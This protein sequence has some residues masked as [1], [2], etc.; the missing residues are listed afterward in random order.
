[1]EALSGGL[2]PNKLDV[3]REYLQNSYDAIRNYVEEGHEL[4]D[5]KIRVLVQ[6]RSVVIQDN[7]GGM[8]LETLKEY[9][10]MGFS[11][12][13]FGTYAGWRGI[14]KAA[15]L[16]VAEKLIVSTAQESNTVGYQLVFQASQMLDEVRQLRRSGEN[17]PFN[18]LIS[19][20]TTIESFEKDDPKDHFTSVELRNVRKEMPELLDPGLIHAHLSQI[21]PVP[22]HSDF[23]HGQKIQEQ[24]AEHLEEYL[25]LIV[26]VNENRV[27]K[28]YLD[29]WTYEEEEFSVKDPEFLPVYNQERE[30]VSFAWYCMNQGKGQIRGPI[31]VADQAV[32][33]SGLVYRLYDIRIGDAQLCRST[34]WR[35]TPERAF[36]AIGEVHVVDSRVEPTSDR[37]D[38]VDNL[39]R[40]D[41]YDSCTVI[42]K[43][44][45]RKAG[46]QSEEL[47]AEEK[48]RTASS[49]VGNISLQLSQGKVSREVVPLY[50]QRAMNARDEL[51]RRL[52]KTTKEETRRIGN[53]A[54]EQ[55]SL[56][57]EQLRLGLEL[58]HV[59]EQG[60][61]VPTQFVDIMEELSLSDEARQVY[62]AVMK[63]VGEFFVDVPGFYEEMVRRIHLELRRTFQP[64]GS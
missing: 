14:G 38:F 24:L 9:R 13:P 6:G 56:L 27:F 42:A 34:I 29:T 26:F 62:D 52:P 16:A 50:I 35:A 57:I 1:L 5:C 32:N 31:S 49:D 60:T 33:V 48:V 2:Y 19:K 28:P 53:S 25:P 36:Y 59:P 8:D 21:A 61:L 11:K 58:P 3:L 51:E 20:F 63:A 64:K 37:N 41:L 22:F 18:Q 23:K 10:K 45:S 15:G 30:L 55:A 4:T 17:I 40:Y 43:E 46:K 12:K 7:A 44:I 54:L 47:R 39:P